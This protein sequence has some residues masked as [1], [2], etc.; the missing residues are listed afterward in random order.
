MLLLSFGR[1]GCI[2]ELGPE[3]M[4]RRLARHK[5]VEEV[6]KKVGTEMMKGERL[7]GWQA[8]WLDRY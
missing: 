8:G 6:Q 5:S 7:A 4:L 1:Q 2:A 3:E